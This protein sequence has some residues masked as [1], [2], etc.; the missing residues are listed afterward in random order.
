MLKKKCTFMCPGLGSE[1]MHAIQNRHNKI[2]VSEM[3]NRLPKCNETRQHHRGI[4]TY[5]IY[6]M[7][8][9]LEQHYA[10]ICICTQKNA[11]K[12]FHSARSVNAYIA[13]FCARD[14]EDFLAEYDMNLVNFISCKFFPIVICFIVWFAHNYNGVFL[15][16]LT[17]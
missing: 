2:Q 14:S 16:N 13:I 4:S 9:P 10:Y 1:C 15:A 8:I 7:H 6:N 3:A 5:K 17:N 12:T 11:F